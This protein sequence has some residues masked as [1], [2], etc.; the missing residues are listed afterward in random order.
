MHSNKTHTFAKFDKP[1]T[2]LTIGID[3]RQSASEIC[4]WNL[5]RLLKLNAKKRTE[6]VRDVFIIIKFID[7][8]PFCHINFCIVL[9]VD[10]QPKMEKKHEFDFFL[11]ATLISS[12]YYIQ[13]KNEKYQVFNSHLW[14]MYRIVY[15]TNH[16]LATI[17]F[18][19]MVFVS[20]LLSLLLLL[21]FHFVFLFD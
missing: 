14:Y 12:F 4:L 18:L 9:L 19:L 11:I 20:L 16:F 2:V 8:S 5:F 17:Q 15:K 21:S 1:S 6:N 10:C 13:Q 7:F 3:L